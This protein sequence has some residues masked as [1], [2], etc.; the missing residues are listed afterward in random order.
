MLSFLDI[1]IIAVALLLSG[2]S[3][4]L[5]SI[6]FQQIII[7]KKITLF[8]ILFFVF[9][10]TLGIIHDQVIYTFVNQFWH[11][12]FCDYVCTEEFNNLHPQI[13]VTEQEACH[14]RHVPFH[15]LPIIKTQ[16][17]HEKAIVFLHGLN[18]SS[19]I[20]KELVE[21][22]KA[23]VDIYAPTLPAH[24]HTLEFHKMN[25]DEITDFIVRYL[26][27]MDAN[28]QTDQLLDSSPYLQTRE[29]PKNW[30]PKKCYNRDNITVIGY[31]MSGLCLTSALISNKIYAKN[32]VFY[33]PSL[34]INVDKL[35]WVFKI[36]SIFFKKYQIFDAY[37]LASTNKNRKARYAYKEIFF[38]C[39]LYLNPV[40]SILN[41]IKFNKKTHK[42]L[43][44]L[45]QDDM[46]SRNHN[47]YLIVSYN[48][49]YI[50]INRMYQCLHDKLQ[51]QDTKVC[52][53]KNGCH[54]FLHIDTSKVELDYGAPESM[55]IADVF[56]QCLQDAIAGQNFTYNITKVK[57]NQA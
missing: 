33:A 40:K 23:D 48:D 57:D 34:A 14:I 43:Q 45:H 53:F 7:W 54:N 3:V 41:L 16:S 12:P 29:Y 46:I 25:C 27:E 17:N 36:Y 26:N 1:T 28:A 13:A 47:I 30:R 56:Q 39:Y 21:T 22:F 31:S 32:L 50:D 19:I 6:V 55:Q 35:Y 15:N 44:N 52:K 18:N 49:K 37:K 11:R 20:W 9:L 51:L 24:Y 38:K 4:V 5:S 8:I 2:L 42:Q 10:K